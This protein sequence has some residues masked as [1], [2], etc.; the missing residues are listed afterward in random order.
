MNAISSASQNIM[1][2]NEY[3]V[4][5]LRYL[6]EH[7]T[8]FPNEVTSSIAASAGMNCSDKNVI[9]LITILTEK[10]ISDVVTEC[11]SESAPGTALYSDTVKRALSKRGLSTHRPEFLVEN[12]PAPSGDAAGDTGSS[13]VNTLCGE[14]NQTNL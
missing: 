9:K 11:R 8:R 4:Q 13:I 2:H 14:D 6:N 10:F 7:Q 3:L 12:A 5:L 1:E